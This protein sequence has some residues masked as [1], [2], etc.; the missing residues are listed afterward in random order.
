MNLRRSCGWPRQ[1]ACGYSLAVSPLSRSLDSFQSFARLSISDLGVLT[2]FSQ[3]PGIA[4]WRLARWSFTF[5]RLRVGLAIELSARLAEVLCFS[6]MKQFWLYGLRA[7][8]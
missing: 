4:Q 1:G 6:N 3:A 2:T 8:C 7:F 5:H